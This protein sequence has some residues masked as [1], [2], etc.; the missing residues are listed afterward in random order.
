M[1]FQ[2]GQSGNPA[3]RPPGARGRAALIAEALFEGEAETI[4]RTAIDKAKEGDLAAVRLCLDRIVPRPR[5]RVVPFELPTLRSAE[6]ALAAVTEIAAA[7]GRGDVTPAQ[8]EDLSRVVDRFL[9]T[10]EWVEFEQR[11]RRLEEN[12]GIR[13][14]RLPA[15]AAEAPADAPSEVQP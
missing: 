4:I 10:L 8:A 3:G 11:V 7:V 13:P 6:S 12:A 2:K 15:P 14:R 5:D 9:G 1:T